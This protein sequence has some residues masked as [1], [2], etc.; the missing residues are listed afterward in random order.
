M[1]DGRTGGGRTGYKIKKRKTLYI[2]MGKKDI[3]GLVDG[4]LNAE[5]KLLMGLWCLGLRGW[6]CQ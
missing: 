4:T 6:G 1:G 3:E 2:Y 5:K